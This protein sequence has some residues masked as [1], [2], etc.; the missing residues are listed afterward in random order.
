MSRVVGHQERPT[1]GRR[2]SRAKSRHVISPEAAGRKKPTECLW[3]ATSCAGRLFPLPISAE[4]VTSLSGRGTVCPIRNG[5]HFPARNGE[6]NSQPRARP[7]H[8]DIQLLRFPQIEV[9]IRRLTGGIPP[10][11]SP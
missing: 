9:R 5:G 10:S 4:K 6:R 2:F 1:S 3:R 8:L 11:R 7:H